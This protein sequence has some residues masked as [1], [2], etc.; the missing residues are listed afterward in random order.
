MAGLFG[1]ARP[2]LGIETELPPPPPKPRYDTR[3]A[4]RGLFGRIGS[5]VTPERLQVLGHTLQEMGGQQGALD[6]YLAQRHAREMDNFARQRQEMMD[7]HQQAEWAR[8]DVQEEALQA[9]VATLTPEQRQMAAANPQAAHEAFMAAQMRSG[10]WEG[11]AGFTNSYRIDPRTG[12]VEM[13]GE[14]PLRPYAPRSSSST[15]SYSGLPPGFDL[16]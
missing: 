6:D 2:R 9:W 15:Q 8:E 13:G 3:P 7:K 16:D 5:L 1:S 14:L 11:G 10:Q 4:R 12:A